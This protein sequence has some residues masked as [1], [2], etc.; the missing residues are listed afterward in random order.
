MNKDEYKALCDRITGSVNR[1][2]NYR[3]NANEL[4]HLIGVA[5]GL[6]EVPEPEPEQAASNT[7]EEDIT[8]DEDTTEVPSSGSDLD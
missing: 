5:H 1:N 3:A 7:V 2:M 8:D 4:L 6:V